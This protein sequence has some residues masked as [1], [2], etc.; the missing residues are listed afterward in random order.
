[1][2]NFYTV[3]REDD[4]GVV[5]FKKVFGSLETAQAAVLADLKSN[6]D[7]SWSRNGEGLV[8]FEAFDDL[9]FSEIAATYY[10]QQAELA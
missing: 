10:I 8:T 3:T 5:P 4:Q 7:G 2:T 9:D 1:M 6:L